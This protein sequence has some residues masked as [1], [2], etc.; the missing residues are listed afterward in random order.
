MTQIDRWWL[1]SINGA[2]GQVEN[3]HQSNG[4]NH[5]P[6]DL[7]WTTHMHVTRV[8]LFGSARASKE[9]G[10]QQHELS[11]HAE[12]GRG[13]E[14]NSGEIHAERCKAGRLYST[15][16]VRVRRTTQTYAASRQLHPWF[17]ASS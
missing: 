1:S 10:A 17:S 16:G 2:P 13:P 3:E 15:V 7:H 6:G 5:S 12:D 8:F 4:W 11:N 14:Q 9:Q